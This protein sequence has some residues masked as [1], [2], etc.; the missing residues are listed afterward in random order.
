[1]FG[2]PT[3]TPATVGLHVRW[4]ATAPAVE[5][6]KGSSVAATDPAA[7]LGRFAVARSTATFTGSEF[8]FSFRT[9]ADVSTDRGWAE[10]GRER[11]GVFLG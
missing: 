1:M 3:G 10:I 7:F 9:N 4:D 8:G 11:N 2:G 5:R 6:G